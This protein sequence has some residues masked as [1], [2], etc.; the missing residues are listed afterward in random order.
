MEATKERVH[1]TFIPH[2][3]EFALSL[4]LLKDHK[5]IL[6]HCCFRQQ[7][8]GHPLKTLLKGFQSRIHRQQQKNSNPHECP[9]L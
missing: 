4:C 3:H 9:A 2:E 8:H 7:V 1:L 6:T 5:Y